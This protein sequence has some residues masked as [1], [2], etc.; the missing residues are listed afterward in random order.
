[1]KDKPIKHILLPVLIGIVSVLLEF[2]VSYKISGMLLITASFFIIMVLI[3]TVLLIIFKDF[4]C[5]GLLL[6]VNCGVMLIIIAIGFILSPGS[7]ISYDTVLPIAANLCAVAATC[8]VTR[9][10]DKSSVIANFSKFFRMASIAFFLFYMVA[11]AVALFFKTP[12]GVRGMSYRSVNMVPFRT[13]IPYLTGIARVNTDIAVSNLLGNLLIFMPLGF[14]LSV[15]SSRIKFWIRIFIALSIPL[16][17]EILQ[18]LTGRGSADID[19]FILNFIG[20]ILGM[21]FCVIVDKIYSV[22]KKDASA[23]L[24]VWK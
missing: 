18:Y 7:R 6:M 8:T 12:A 11:L 4:I 2:F 23:R 24:F 21:V 22:V 1:V 13:I 5:C 17:V 16:F 9:L 10:F 19:D 15:L 14:Y 3:S 20:A